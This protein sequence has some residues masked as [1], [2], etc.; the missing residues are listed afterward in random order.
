MNAFHDKMKPHS[1][2]ADPG[3]IGFRRDGPALGA[4]M[5]ARPAASRRRCKSAIFFPS[6]L[7]AAVWAVLFEMP[8]HANQRQ[9][10]PVEN[11]RDAVSPAAD[12]DTS[13]HKRPRAS[14]ATFA[15]VSAMTC[16][17]ERVGLS[18]GARRK[19]QGRICDE[20]TTRH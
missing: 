14:R 12:I 13:C 4:A 9:H 19:K 2:A 7:T 20:N 5:T 8:R 3:L 18:A 16:E 10:R 17:N 6:N 11:A 15:V 1:V